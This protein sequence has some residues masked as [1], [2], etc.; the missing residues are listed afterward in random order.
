MRVSD[1]AVSCTH[2]LFSTILIK[3]KYSKSNLGFQMDHEH[4]FSI[5]V[6]DF[7]GGSDGEESACNAGDV[8][9]IP[10]SGRSPGEGNGNPLRILPKKSHGQRS[11]ASYSL[12]GL[13]E[14]QT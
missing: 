13:K 5:R 1:A 3:E 9:S 14:D 7:P 10:G 11:L 8:G 12:R 4:L 2:S 6:W